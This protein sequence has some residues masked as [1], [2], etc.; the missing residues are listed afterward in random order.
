MRERR[1][2]LPVSAQY[3]GIYSSMRLHVQQYEHTYYYIFWEKL[4]SDGVLVRARKQHTKASSNSS[5]LNSFSQLF[6]LHVCQTFL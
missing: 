1:A 5:I 6:G 4:F 2:L 3:E